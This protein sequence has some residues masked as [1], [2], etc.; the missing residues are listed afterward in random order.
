MDK[1]KQ[2]RGL[3]GEGGERDTVMYAAGAVAEAVLVGKDAFH[4]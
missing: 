3:S 4:S 1:L 2:F